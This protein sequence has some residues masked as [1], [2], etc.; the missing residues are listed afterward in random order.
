VEQLS[1]PDKLRFFREEIKFE[2]S[3]LAQ[4]STILV[5]CQSFLVVP[6]AILHTAASF[7]AVVVLAYITA[8]LGIFVALLLRRPLNAAHRAID[9]WLLKQ[10]ALLKVSEELEDLKI[11]RDSIPGV[12]ENLKKDRDH[13][14]SLAFSRYG[15]WAFCVFWIAAALWSTVRVVWGF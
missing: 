4:R 10:R 6:F 1:N 8:G 13:V 15:P 12:D 11:D 9:K 2:F 14:M 3:L 5:T 7:R